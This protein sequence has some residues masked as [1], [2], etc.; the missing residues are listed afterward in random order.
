MEPLHHSTSTHFCSARPLTLRSTGTGLRSSARSCAGS[1]ARLCRPAGPVLWAA[2]PALTSASLGWAG[3][4]RAEPNAGLELP[5][6]KHCL[7]SATRH[8]GRHTELQ[9]R[10]RARHLHRRHGLQGP[11]PQA[12]MQRPQHQYSPTLPA[13]HC[14]TYPDPTCP[15]C[16]QPA[17]PLG[18]LSPP[19]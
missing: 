2:R 4:A 18:I 19:L 6:H 3:N 1:G 12:Q 9:S 15:P 7:S 16:L 14:L 13:H 17:A 10:D 5:R 11:H 8:T